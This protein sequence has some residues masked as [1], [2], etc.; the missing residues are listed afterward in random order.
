[1]EEARRE[2][3]EKYR[4]ILES[5]EDGYFEVDQTG[6][7]TFLNNS[8]CRI[9]GHP[10]N[11]LLGMNVRTFIDER[12]ADKVFEIFK[13]VYSTGEPKNAIDIQ[14]KSK[15]GKKR[16]IESSVSPRTNSED[17]IVGL[18]GIV[19][20][21]TDRIL[22]KEKLANYSKHLEEIIQALN[23]AQEVQQSLLPRYLP[24]NKFIDVAGKSLFCDETGGDYYDH[25]ELTR[26]G[27]DTHAF[28]VGDVSGHGISSALLMASVRAYLRGRAMYADSIAEIISDVNTLISADTR[29]TGN[30]MTLFFLVVEPQTG[31]IT[32]VRAGHHPALSYSPYT[33][34]F[35]EIGG[36]GL[37]LG[38]AEDWRY[39]EYSSKVK[40]GEI[41]ILSTDGAWETH[42]E[43]GEMLGQD[44]FKEIISRN[45]S[46][47]SK[48][49]LNSIL[50]EIADFQGAAPQEDDITLMVLKFL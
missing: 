19:R 21:V 9:F 3:E 22:A 41:L 32:W 10:E 16:W 11:E 24:R 30:F 26:F 20:D 43:Q 18:R 27:P 17:L 1:M 48:N 28:V 50:D 42:N 23:V 44:R 7:L 2:S 14:I 40:S 34:C 38:V 8:L 13:Q 25:I 5:I 31:R 35:E 45:V 4:S 49:I 15:D 37:P 12:F 29:K 46:L 36:D 33:G 39:N 6:N 47:D